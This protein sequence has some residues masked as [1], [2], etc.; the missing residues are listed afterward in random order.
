MSVML[1]IFQLTV[2]STITIFLSAQ[3]LA[4]E[5]TN[6]SPAQAAAMHTEKKA[7]IV[8]VREDQEWDETHIPGAIHIPLNQLPAR[9]AELESYKNSPIIAQCQS[10]R[11]SAQAAYTLTA[12][13]FT[14]VLNLDGGLLA[15]NRAGLATE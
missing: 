9:L 11:R 4:N 6:I 2:L 3:C 13:G 10:G 1:K 7:V 5:I 12:A 15:W 14:K 8:D